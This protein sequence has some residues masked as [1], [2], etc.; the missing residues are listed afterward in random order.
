M[1]AACRRPA[2]IL[3]FPLVTQAVPQHV[4]SQPASKQR[5]Q[6]AQGILRR[7]ACNGWSASPSRVECVALMSARPAW[8]AHA[9]PSSDA[10]CGEPSV[11]ELGHLISRLC[12]SRRRRLLDLLMVR[13]HDAAHAG[14]ACP[15]ES[16]WHTGLPKPH[17]CWAEWAEV[18]AKALSYC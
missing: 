14:M 15:P 11:P 18:E 1:A 12:A 4:H 6:P 13:G 10:G 16:A 5:H 8:P 9:L 7:F 2:A 17:P 3:A